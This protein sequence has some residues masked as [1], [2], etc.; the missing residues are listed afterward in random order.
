MSLLL[1]ALKKAALEKQHRS[2]ESQQSFV[3]PAVEDLGPSD[4]LSEQVDES[5]QVNATVPLHESA[6]D[7]TP[8]EEVVA[9]EVA[10]EPSGTEDSDQ[11]T[12][13]VEEDSSEASCAIDAD[14]D[15]VSGL[16]EKQETDVAD[17]APDSLPLDDDLDDFDWEIGDAID[18]DDWDQETIHEA[19]E[20]P[21][22]SE[23]DSGS[24]AWE[25]LVETQESD[26]HAQ[27]EADHTPELLHPDTHFTEEPS[28][29]QNEADLVHLIDEGHR[30]ASQ[31][32]RRA[33]FLYLMLMLT[34]LGGILAYYFFLLGNNDASELMRRSG[35]SLSVAG[36]QPLELIP[37]EYDDTSEVVPAEED[38]TNQPL[39]D[40]GEPGEA[41]SLTEDITDEPE[42]ASESDF[43]EPASRPA[44]AAEAEQSVNAEPGRDDVIERYDTPPSQADLN[45]LIAGHFKK[46]TTPSSEPAQQLVLN[47]HA[48]KS[49]VFEVIE[50]GYAAFRSDDLPSAE[51]LYRRAL[52]MAPDNRD[53][54]LG[55]A[56]VA[57]RQS[58][59]GMAAELYERR[60]RADPTDSY[61]RAGLLSLANQTD[62]RQ[63]RAELEKLLAE[64]PDTAYFHSLKGMNQVASEDWLGAQESFYRAFY[65]DDR[66]PDYAYNLAISL[67]HLNQP[68]QA[69]RYYRKA[70]ELNQQFPSSFD[71]SAATDR[72]RV[73]GESL[74]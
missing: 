40:S 37:E 10:V 43:G 64:Y 27:T 62:R 14:E 33:N 12:V 13:L 4:T 56:A 32:R 55:A 31:S 16:H 36:D 41:L 57:V 17:V 28:A 70:L 15:L 6:P 71:V 54:L 24:D 74:P 69:R 29:R 2:R 11:D 9:R 20:L 68:D 18:P 23:P 60:L 46:S 63:I 34:T 47:H 30:V 44:V 21:L 1:E 49:D 19:E 35:V 51:S 65:L 48:R 38:A 25:V 53:A 45:A 26:D 8:S 58:Q 39:A 66:N 67:D 22:D 73:L 61:A 52:V 72:L 42:P 5:A 7:K 50:Q 3:L 59:W